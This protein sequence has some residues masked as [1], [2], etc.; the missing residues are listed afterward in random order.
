MSIN[1]GTD[2]DVVHIH[3]GG[4]GNPLQN[5]CL[6]NPM[7]RGAWWVIVHGV[8]KSR[9]RLKWLSPY[10]QWNITHKEQN[11]VICRDVDAPRVCHTEWSKSGSCFYIII[12]YYYFYKVLYYCCTKV[13]FLSTCRESSSWILKRKMHL[14]SYTPKNAWWLCP[15]VGLWIILFSWILFA[16][17]H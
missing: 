3:R 6:E 10:I 1:R 9:T 4:H 11:W 13:I 2:K 14:N 5:S 16:Y 7:D 17:P 8:A 15:G 12:Q